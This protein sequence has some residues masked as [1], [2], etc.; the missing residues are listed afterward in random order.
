MFGEYMDLDYEDLVADLGSVPLHSD[1][2]DQCR[3][4]QA[5]ITLSVR[6]RFTCQ[7]LSIS[8]I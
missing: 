3:H 5:R 2:I 4:G 7:R 8:L 1:G 6:S